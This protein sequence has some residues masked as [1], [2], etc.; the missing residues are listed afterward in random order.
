MSSNSRSLDELNQAERD[1]AGAVVAA[2]RA[3]H[4]N[5]VRGLVNRLLQLFTLLLPGG[6]SL[7]VLLHR[8][9]GVHIGKNVWVSYNVV[10]ETAYPELITIDD[11]AFIGIGVIVIAHFREARRGVRIGKQAFVGPGVIILPDLEI[12][13]GAVVTAGSVVTSSV[14]SM[15]VVQGNPATPIAKCSVPLRPDTTL[16]EFSRRLRPIPGAKR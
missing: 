15:T 13:D 10:L 4:E 5:P 6:Q 1:R 16:K 7:R 14:P 11:D 8:M 2:H 12:G 3:M 9:R